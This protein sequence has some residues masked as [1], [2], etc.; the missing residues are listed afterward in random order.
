MARSFFV[1]RSASG[2]VSASADGKDVVFDGRFYVGTS[3]QPTWSHEDI[4]EGAI[5][6]QIDPGNRYQIIVNAAF[7]EDADV[8]VT[9]RIGDQSKTVTLSGDADPPGLD[10]QLAE[11]HIYTPT[12]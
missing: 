12:S 1:E 9:C 8:T 6:F 2:T 11:F 3:P 4:T 7:A 10:Y 5:A